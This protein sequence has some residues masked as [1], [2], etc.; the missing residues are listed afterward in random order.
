MYEAFVGLGQ[1]RSAPDPRGTPE[2]ICD[3]CA[4]A[5]ANHWG[6]GDWK[7]CASSDCVVAHHFHE[8]RCSLGS[9]DTEATRA[10]SLRYG[11][12]WLLDKAEE[13]A[14]KKP[15]GSCAFC[16]VL[17]EPQHPECLVAT[18]ATHERAGWRL[19]HR[20]QLGG[21]C[22]TPELRAEVLRHVAAD[23]RLLEEGKRDA[24]GARTPLD[25]ELTRPYQKEHPSLTDQKAPPE[26]IPLVGITPHYEWP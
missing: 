23:D 10:E 16:S 19:T 3:F 6:C 20:L 13:D 2:G 22:D 21:V 7:I 12:R 24:T 26:Q 15:E 9:V 8:E 11:K 1:V 5:P 25:Y 17:A 18:C 14:Q 4:E